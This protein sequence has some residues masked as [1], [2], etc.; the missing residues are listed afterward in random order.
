VKISA[1][2]NFREEDASTYTP[3]RAEASDTY[4]L[5]LTEIL[6]WLESKNHHSMSESSFVSPIKSA[7]NEG[8]STNAGHG[9]SYSGSMTYN[10]ASTIN[11]S[12]SKMSYSASKIGGSIGEGSIREL[13]SR[14]REGV[15]LL[16]G[17]RERKIKSQQ[18]INIRVYICINIFSRTC[19]CGRIY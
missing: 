1:S 5:A 6:A 19:I 4:S 10:S 8:S 17:E 11:N 7:S 15:K 12:A 2:S 18:V 13:I 3:N 9:G 14:V 16:L